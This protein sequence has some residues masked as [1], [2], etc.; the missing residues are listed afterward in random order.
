[1]DRLRSVV[2]MFVN[3]LPIV[4]RQN[5]NADSPVILNPQTSYYAHWCGCYSPIYGRHVR[6]MSQIGWFSRLGV[7]DSWPISTCDSSKCLRGPPGHYDILFE[8]V[9]QFGP[10]LLLKR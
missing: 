4:V 3:L 9:W 8:S 2:A 1:M 10:K 6:K 7:C 5:V